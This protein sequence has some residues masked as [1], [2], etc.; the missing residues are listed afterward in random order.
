V[1]ILF[2]DDVSANNDS[3]HLLRGRRARC[4]ASG[5]VGAACL[6]GCVCW[7]RSQNCEKRLSCLSARVE[8]HG[9]HLTEFHEI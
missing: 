7:T 6:A 1:P 2:C 4:M 8:R 5:T 9:S 3:G